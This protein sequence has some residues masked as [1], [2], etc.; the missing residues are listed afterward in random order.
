MSQSAYPLSWPV[1]WPR[2]SFRRVSNFGAHSVAGATEE[3]LAQLKMLGVG[4]WNVVISTNLA[5]RNDGLPRSDQKTP[6][7]PGVAIYFKL[8]DRPTVLACDKWGKVEENI[9][10]IAKH[11]D[12]MRGQNR[13][14]VG[15][16]EKAFAGY[17]ALPA[18][19]ESTAATWY[20]VL[21]VQEACTFEY[22]QERYREEARACHPDARGGSHESMV[23]LNTAWDMARKHFGR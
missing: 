16:V 6:A 9:W 8:K 13:W 19:G 7:D 10:A 2:T 5:L 22:A 3:V 23:R 4:N 12:A 18:P 14:G 1:N 11:I 21:G 15:N 17:A 20:N